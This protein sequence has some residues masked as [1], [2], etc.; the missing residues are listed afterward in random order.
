MQ[1]AGKGCGWAAASIY[2]GRGQAGRL[3][4]G[5]GMGGELAKSARCMHGMAWMGSGRAVQG[6]VGLICWFDWQGMQGTV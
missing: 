5:V 6:R 4:R 1:A 2:G 3:V